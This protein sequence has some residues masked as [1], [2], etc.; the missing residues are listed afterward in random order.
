MTPEDFDFLVEKVENAVKHRCGVIR[1]IGVPRGGPIT[2]QCILHGV[3]LR[4]VG[5]LALSNQI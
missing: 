1:T 4:P 2:L 5:K 3:L